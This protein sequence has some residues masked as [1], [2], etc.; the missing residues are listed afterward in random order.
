MSRTCIICG[1]VANSGE[2]VFPAA[3]GGRRI[4]RGIYCDAHNNEFSRHVSVL[5]PQFSYINALLGIRHDREKQ[6]RVVTE[7][8]TTGDEVVIAKGTVRRA[9]T[10]PTS[11][12]E[13]IHLQMVFGGDEFL[14][15][16]AYVA[17]TFFAHYFPEEARQSGVTQVKA[18]VQGRTENTMAWWES[19][20]T[21]AS[22]RPNPFEFGHTIVLTT[23]GATGIASALVS[24]FQSL[25][26]GVDLGSIEKPS[27]R[28]VVVFIDPHADHP[29][30]DLQV[31]ESKAVELRLQKPEPL[32]AHLEQMVRGGRGQRLL[33]RLFEK[34]ERWHFRNEMTPV[35]DRL[36]AA[37]PMDRKNRMQEIVG[38]VEEQVG[39]VYR[40]MKFV[41]DEF[42][43]RSKDDE[44]MMPVNLALQEQIAI[45]DG[46]PRPVA[47]AAIQRAMIV[48]VRELD[49]KLSN[50]TVDMYYLWDIF[51]AGPG[52]ALI[53]EA[54]LGPVKGALEELKDQSSAAVAGGAAE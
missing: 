33:A 26:V 10:S 50:G 53:A 19:A 42:A 17:L 16:A 52:A 2:H 54:M 5:A 43:E 7:T 40:L 27:D 14:Q 31:I 41:V 32:H 51:S 23:V 22:L 3:L 20:A 46:V 24:F 37:A 6:P 29:P 38:I 34:I 28:T 13:T 21:T 1:V 48:L 36:N 18:F 35:L 45:D 30:G 25:T 15:A 49:A 12:E 8:T 11:P 4:N 9:V 47:E 44:K 39:R